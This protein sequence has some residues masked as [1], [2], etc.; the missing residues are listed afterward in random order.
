M[1]LSMAT[2]ND[3]VGLGSGRIREL[4][5]LQGTDYNS[6]LRIRKKYLRIRKKF[7]RIHWL[8]SVY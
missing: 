2:K 4:I 6:G 1:I 8:L 5:G 3:Q 7:L